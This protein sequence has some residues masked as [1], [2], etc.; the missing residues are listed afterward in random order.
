MQFTS[1]TAALASCLAI[2]AIPAIASAAKPQNPG[3]QG[4]GHAE[5]HAKGP[6]QNPAENRSKK[7]SENPSEKHSQRCKKTT[8]NKAFVVSGSYTNGSFTATK[9]NPSD[10]RST[11]SG[12]VALLVK[13][14]NRHAQAF[15]GQQTFKFSHAKVTFDSPT[16]TG[17]NANDNVKLIGKIVV[18]KKKC[19]GTGGEITIR[20]IVFSIPEPAH[21]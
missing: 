5:H 21:S 16:A 17:P 18:V 6:S 2:A 4:K 9:D 19:T 3:S 14:T 12:S 15:T 13:K 1:R 11:Y 20:K 8:T 10:P 7:P